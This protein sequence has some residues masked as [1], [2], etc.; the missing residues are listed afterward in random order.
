MPCKQGRTGAVRIEGEDCCAPTT[1][2]LRPSPPPACVTPV[3]QAAPDAQPAWQ[4]KS[5][6]VRIQA[7]EAGPLLALSWYDTG[8]P[9]SD[10]LAL[11]VRLN[12]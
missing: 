2:E 7:V 10:P 11:Y 8:P 4:A 3:A 1:Y 12:I 5:E 6:P 9:R